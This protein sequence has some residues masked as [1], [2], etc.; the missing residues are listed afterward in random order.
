MM[1]RSINNKSREKD[2][3]KIYKLLQIQNLNREN[4][5]KE[6]N[7]NIDTAGKADETSTNIE[8]SFSCKKCNTNFTSRQ[9]LKEH[10]SSQH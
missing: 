9:E 3:I 6:S 7:R 8:S 4:Q 5:E 2:S 10:F 1:R